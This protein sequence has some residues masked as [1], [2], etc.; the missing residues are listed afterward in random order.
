MN[1]NQ[2]YQTQLMAMSLLTDKKPVLSMNQILRLLE[3]SNRTVMRISNHDDKD[4]KA[5]YHLIIE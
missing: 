5:I 2:K 3:I 1:I 4:V